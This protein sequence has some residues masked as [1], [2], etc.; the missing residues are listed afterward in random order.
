MS[1]LQELKLTPLSFSFLFSPPFKELIEVDSEVVF[2]LAAYILQVSTR[3]PSLRASLCCVK[4]LDLP[5]PKWLTEAEGFTH[6][7]EKDV[8]TQFS[9]LIPMQNRYRRLSKP[10]LTTQGADSPA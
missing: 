10:D 1:F 3:L 5:N 9:S 4:S 8:F 2:E 6:L 7:Q